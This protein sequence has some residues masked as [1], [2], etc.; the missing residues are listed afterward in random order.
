M[1]K[2]KII[3]NTDLIEKY[4]DGE[5]Q[6]GELE[7]FDTRM[8]SDPEFAKE[9]KLHRELNDFLSR[10]VDYI[11]KREQLD[12]IY[13]EVILK[14]R[15]L[16]PQNLRFSINYSFIWQ[17]KVA[18]GISFLIAIAILLFF[19]LR[20][21]K[22]ERLYAQYFKPF[23]VYSVTRSA[24]D[25]IPDKFDIA[26][27]EYNSGNFQKAFILFGKIS[28]EDTANMSALFYE[29][30]SAMALSKFEKASFLFEKIIV[31]NTSLYTESAEWYLA[32]CYLQNPDLKNPR[33]L[34][35]K[36][37]NSKSYYRKEASAILSDLPK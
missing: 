1:N 22:N 27:D 8:I 6:G 14:K 29:G 26:L 30:I 17:Y 12:K 5:L 10:K 18:I 34:L 33:E 35:T 21:P 23:E 36:I 9:V 15:E 3:D 32:L 13:E 25:Q 4:F 19:I 31:D 28:V 24:S 37:A 7:D 20:P 16:S 11:Q 2:R